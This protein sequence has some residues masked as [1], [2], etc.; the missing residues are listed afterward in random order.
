MDTWCVHAWC[1]ARGG[2]ISDGCTHGAQ[3]PS[4]Q[5]REEGQWRHVDPGVRMTLA[6]ARPRDWDQQS[7]RCGRHAK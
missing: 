7:P 5:A 4:A 1:G 3:T 2:Q 6:G